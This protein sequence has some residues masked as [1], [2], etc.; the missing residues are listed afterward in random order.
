MKISELTSIQFIDTICANYHH[1]YIEEANN[2]MPVPNGFD[3]DL[4]VNDQLRYIDLLNQLIKMFENL[5]H[6]E[7]EIDRTE[8]K[9]ALITK[10]PEICNYYDRQME[11]PANRRVLSDDFINDL[12]LLQR[13]TYQDFFKTKNRD[14]IDIFLNNHISPLSEMRIKAILA[15]TNA[16]NEKAAITLQR[17]YRSKQRDGLHFL[18]FSNQHPQHLLPPPKNI[19][20]NLRL[21]SIINE[22]ASNHAAVNKVQYHWTTTGNLSSILRSQYLLG[23]N[24][25]KNNKIFFQANA[26]CIDDVANGDDKVIC[27]CPY[28]VDHD[29]I[30]DLYKNK[31]RNNLIRLSININQIKTQGKYNQFFKLRDLLSPNF[32]YDAKIND[33]LSISVSGD[34]YCFKFE[35]TINGKA[36]EFCLYQSH[37]RS[38]K[39]RQMHGIIY[40]GNLISINR[41]CLLQ[42]FKSIEQAHDIGFS[43]EFFS[44]LNSLDDNEIKKIL[45]IFAQSLTVFAEYNFNAA[46]KLSDHLISEIHYVESN[47]TL[48]LDNLSAEEYQHVMGTLMN[49]N[50]ADLNLPTTQEV[51][52]ERLRLKEGLYLYGNEID[53]NQRTVSYIKRDFSNIPATCFAGN[54]YVETRFNSSVELKKSECQLSFG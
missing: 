49:G 25:L 11:N 1:I 48:K 51:L 7:A 16:H 5:A 50:V 12:T 54:E 35:I 9:N 24:I 47:T 6:E 53:T 8:I 32:N 31:I 45:V 19:R 38:E 22:L 44:Y 20:E 40:Y 18:T 15:E 3:E 34:R 14:L 17:H 29:A 52:V 36:K 26:L 27:F 42:L 13:L 43:S 10:L 37:L 21:L 2:I 39:V 28:L 30:W 41:F 33:A 4:P 23:N 46:V